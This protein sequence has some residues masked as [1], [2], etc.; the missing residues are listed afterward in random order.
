MSSN[1]P[2]DRL[3]HSCS[4]FAYSNKYGQDPIF[5]ESITEASRELDIPVPKIKELICNGCN[6]EARE[7]GSYSFDIPLWCEF[8]VVKTLINGKLKYKIIKTLSS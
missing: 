7:S 5:F 6:T 3:S 8:D 1:R 2:I 4:V